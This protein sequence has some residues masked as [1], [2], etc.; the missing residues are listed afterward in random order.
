MSCP[1]TK[2]TIQIPGSRRQM[3]SQKKG[4]E[5]SSDEVSIMFLQCSLSQRKLLNISD[6]NFNLKDHLLRSL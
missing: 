4:G 3:N 2:Y 1:L 6:G 5:T